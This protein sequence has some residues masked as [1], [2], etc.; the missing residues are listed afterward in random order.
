MQ[1]LQ[2]DDRRLIPAMTLQEERAVNFLA[3]VTTILS[4]FI[5]T[6]IA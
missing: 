2:H 6:V 3:V 5:F 1:A 4:A